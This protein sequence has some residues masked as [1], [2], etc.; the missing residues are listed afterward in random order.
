MRKF[1]VPGVLIALALFLSVWSYPHLPD[2]LTIHWGAKGEPNGF[3]PKSSALLIA[4]ILMVVLTFLFRSLAAAGPQSQEAA[5][6]HAMQAIETMTLL[7][8]LAV[9]ALMI[10]HGLGHP[11]N[12]SRAALLLVGLLM[13]GL[14]S[15]LPKLGPNVYAGIRTPWTLAD[16][17]VWRRTHRAA[18]PIFTSGGVAMIAGLL[19]LPAGTARYVLFGILAA[20]ILLVLGLSYYFAKKP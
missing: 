18:G 16:K 17:T 2:T 9:H 7:L 14:G 10:V 13:I 4:P 3:A 5:H 12:M 6:R 8:L 1:M 11:L 19:W 20:T 15:V